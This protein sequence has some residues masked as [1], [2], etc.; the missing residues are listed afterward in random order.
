MAISKSQNSYSLRM[1]VGHFSPPQSVRK[2][3]SAPSFNVER[4]NAIYMAGV[5]H[6]EDS[7]IQSTTWMRY[8]VHKVDR[9]NG[10]IIV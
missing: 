2:P 5:S 10:K 9:S 7:T 8:S 4:E 3:P 6:L 1:E